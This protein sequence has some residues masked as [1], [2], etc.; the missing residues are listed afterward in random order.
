MDEDDPWTEIMQVSGTR[1]GTRANP[2]GRSGKRIMLSKHRHGGMEAEEA[3]A[4][5]GRVFQLL[6]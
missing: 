6:I 5:N 1:V 3:H 2:K 4:I